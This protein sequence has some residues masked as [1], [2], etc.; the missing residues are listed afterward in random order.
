MTPR[1]FLLS[2][3]LSDDGQF[4]NVFLLIVSLI[5][6][7]GDP[8]IVA[9]IYRDEDPRDVELSVLALGW[10]DLSPTQVADALDAFGCTSLMGLEREILRVTDCDYHRNVRR[11]RIASVVKAFADSMEAE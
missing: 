2:L 6:D 10:G 3:L 1:A 5:V 4:Q 9:R 11:L 8:A 7:I